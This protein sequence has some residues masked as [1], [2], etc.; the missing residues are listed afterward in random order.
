MRLWT[1]LAVLVLCSIAPAAFA[2]SVFSFD[3][4]AAGQALPFSLSVNGLTAS[5]EGNG[6]VCP[7]AG[8][9]GNLFV[10]LT[11]NAIMQGFCGNT[12]PGN[13]PLAINFSETVGK[14]TFALALHG[15]A[16]VPVTVT[17]LQNGTIV[18][19]QTI[20]PVVPNGSLCPEAVV[21]YAGGFNAVTLSSTALLAVNN[22]D[23]VPVPSA[24]R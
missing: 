21:T 6:A 24:A 2:E 8:F 3:N 13:G 4:V 12:N 7:T 15:T 17:Y 18:G 20:Q 1:R 19:T 9:S 23:A 16:P 10:A 22:V 14:L 11:G 5:F